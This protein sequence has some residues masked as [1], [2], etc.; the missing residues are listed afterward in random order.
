MLSAFEA[1]KL[2]RLWKEI[3]NYPSIAP[4]IGCVPFVLIVAGVGQF[5]STFAVRGGGFDMMD[6]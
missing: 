5:S 4:Y 2:N 6:V 1:G 3:I